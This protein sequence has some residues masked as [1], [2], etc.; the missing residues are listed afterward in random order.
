MKR[1]SWL[2]SLNRK[3]HQR[4]MNQIIR[5]M[6]KSIENDELWRGRFYARQIA[7]QWSLYE[8]HSGADLWVV[9]RFYDR[10]TGFTYDYADTVN[11]WRYVSAGRLWW[12]MNEFIVERTGVWDE[13]PRPGTEE[14]YK[15][16]DWGK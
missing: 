3:R 4:A 6:N 7:S 12:T 14:W 1:F 13:N 2:T 11:H 8:D 16:M 15:N 5:E 9:L 10:K